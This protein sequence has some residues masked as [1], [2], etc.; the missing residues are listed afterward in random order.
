MYFDS[1][2]VSILSFAKIPC[3]KRTDGARTCHQHCITMKPDVIF[4]QILCPI[5]QIL[6]NF[7]QNRTNNTSTLKTAGNGSTLVPNQ[8]E[9]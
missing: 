8:M 7:I 1:F 5:K 9:K 4:N 6:Q 2:P 3:N